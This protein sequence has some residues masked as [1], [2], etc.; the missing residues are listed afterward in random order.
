MRRIRYAV[1]L[2][3]PLLVYGC[4]T[5]IKPPNEQPTFVVKP[6][7]ITLP[8]N[9]QWDLQGAV[10]IQYQ[11][12]AHIGSVTWQQV[13]DRYAINLY[14]PLNIGAIGIAG[15]PY[16]VTLNK[17]T[18]SYSAATPEALMQQQLGWYLPISNMYYWVRALPAPGKIQKQVRNDDKR[19]VFLQQ[20]GWTIQY[21]AFQAG[22]QSSLP[23]KIVLDNQKLHVKLVINHWNIS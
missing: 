18:G 19:L 5:Q 22:D 7:K 1:S 16:K 23:Q 14:G 15:T 11:G 10:S 3:I 9:K 17:P 4:A 12:K 21:Q 13:N 2:L 8:N 6:R 20:Q